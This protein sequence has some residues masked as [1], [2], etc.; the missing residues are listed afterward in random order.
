MKQFHTYFFSGL[1]FF[2]SL[3]VVAASVLEAPNVTLQQDDIDRFLMYKNMQGQPLS[4][5]QREGL[6]ET[7]FLREKL[8][9]SETAKSITASDEFN[10]IVN[11]FRKD[12]LAQKVLEQ[13]S[14][15]DVP[16]FT[17]RAKELYQANLTAK[18]TLPERYQVNTLSF[19]KHEQENLAKAHE[20]L[21]K[22]HTDLEGISKAHSAKLEER[23][24][25]SQNSARKVWETAKNLLENKQT[26]SE[27]IHFREESQLLVL[28]D[29]KPAEVIPFEKIKDELLNEL[30]QEYIE[31]HRKD[32][33]NTLKAEY[34]AEAKIN[35]AYLQE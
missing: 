3:S 9:T 2:F 24:I 22:D 29:S 34:K 16:D 28:L 10:A 31:N 35:E 4:R 14:Q 19:K 5:E 17:D 27:P 11:E 25:S 15:Q 13:Q 1:F 21:Q 26:V 32:I 20:Q 18:Y 8:S 6:L 7:L 23:W 12:L 33:I 30:K